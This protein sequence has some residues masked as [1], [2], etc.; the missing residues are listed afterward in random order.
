MSL[1]GL[2]V[3]DKP[4][5]PTSHDVVSR[6]RRVLRE[7]RI[8]HTGTLDP[9][10]S[11][12]LL[13]V[14]GRATRLAQFLNTDAKRY[15]ATIHLGF[16]TDTYD[17]LGHPTSAPFDGVLPPRERIEQALD[18]FR[19]TFAQQP[20]AFSAKKIDGRRSY[21]L[22][23]AHRRASAVVGALPAPA[24]LAPSSMRALARPRRS[25]FGAEAGLP[26]LLAPLAL[27]APVSVTVA[28]LEL[29]DVDHDLIR[30][31]LACSSGFYV[32]SLAHDLG[33]RLGVGAHLATL[34]RTEASGRTLSDSV[35]LSQLEEPSDGADRARR[36]LVPL[37]DV[38]PDLPRLTLTPD[39]VRRAVSGCDIGSRD[40]SLDSR[41]DGLVPLPPRVRL[42]NAA[43][44]L[45]GI[46]D[47][48]A[49][50]LLHPVVVLM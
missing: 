32:R 26:G 49:S 11:G 18:A 19:G 35:P 7:R 42:L 33:A 25:P 45:V 5:G 17:A 23:R 31:N 14:V 40:L 39:G 6:V 46:A 9:L 48:T 41:F 4:V 10:A 37:A 15:E 27:P 13:L 16:S 34:R 20:P 24:S 29:L 22:A 38:L 21:R 43:Q 50:G 36:A 1:D 47:L 12:V 3:I 30:I 44:D 2:L 28:K 8:G